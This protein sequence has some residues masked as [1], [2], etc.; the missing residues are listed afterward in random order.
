[1]SREKYSVCHYIDFLGDTEIIIQ[2]I[3][4]VEK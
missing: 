1:M 4:Q 2:T 3:Q